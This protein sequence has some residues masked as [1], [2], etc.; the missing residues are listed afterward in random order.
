[1]NLI[2]FVGNQGKKLIV[3]GAIITVVVIGYVDYVTGTDISFSIFYLLPITA[4]AWHVGKGAGTVI[5]LESSLALLLTDVMGGGRYSNPSVPYWNAAMGLGI[6]LIITIILS[7]L[8]DMYLH[9]EEKVNE[10]T[11]ALT[12]E[13]DRRKQLEQVEVRMILQLEEAIANIK[14]LHGLLPICAWCKKIRT[15]SG[16]WE[17]IEAYVKEHSEADFTHGICP[18]CSVKRSSEQSGRRNG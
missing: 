5:S 4:V 18:E 2:E 7:L 10:K 11:A 13:I 16:Y 9:L 14:T 3:A 17:H 1:M 15:D 8:R 12:L 6:F